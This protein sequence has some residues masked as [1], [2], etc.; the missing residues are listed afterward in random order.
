MF[1][2]MKTDIMLF[3]YFCNLFTRIPREK[4]P[5]ILR[6]QLTTKYKELT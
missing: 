3:V 2:Q 1:E 5:Q 6:I 4:N